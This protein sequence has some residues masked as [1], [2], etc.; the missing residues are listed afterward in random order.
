MSVVL[1]GLKDTIGAFLS[2]EVTRPEL[3]KAISQSLVNS[4]MVTLKSLLM[5]DV[6]VP[7]VQGDN[8]TLKTSE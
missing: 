8:S 4:V 2:K 5:L 7:V 3:E 6:Q 1:H